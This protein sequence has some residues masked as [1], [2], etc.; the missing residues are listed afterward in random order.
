MD[1]AATHNDPKSEIIFSVLSGHTSFEVFTSSRQYRAG[2]RWREHALGRLRRGL[3]G[4]PTSKRLEAG[5]ARA[6]C[7]S[8]R[9]RQSRV[10]LLPADGG[11]CDEGGDELLAVLSLARTPTRSWLFVSRLSRLCGRDRR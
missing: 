2:A 4:G 10:M 6:D 1:V 7:V 8:A 3:E 11:W 5:Q 9:Q